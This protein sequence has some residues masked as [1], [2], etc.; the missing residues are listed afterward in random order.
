MGCAG[1]VQA[2]L[3]QTLVWLVGEVARWSDGAVTS[4]T[5]AESHRRIPNSSPKAPAETCCHFISNPNV[6]R[7]VYFFG[8]MYGSKCGNHGQCKRNEDDAPGSIQDQIAGHDGDSMDE[9]GRGG[10]RRERKSRLGEIFKSI[11]AA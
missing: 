8:C 6:L 5:I 9:Q 3:G 1:A 7:N 2:S 10:G 4:D 11:R